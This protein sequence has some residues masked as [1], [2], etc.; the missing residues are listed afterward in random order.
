MVG[1]V[2]W[3]TENGEAAQGIIRGL[4]MQQVSILKLKQ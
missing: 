2:Q 4:G 3:A 1:Q